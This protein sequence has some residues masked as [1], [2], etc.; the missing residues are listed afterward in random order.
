MDK[1]EADLEVKIK[2]LKACPDYKNSCW[3]CSKKFRCDTRDTYV[4]AVYKSMNKGKDGG[5]EF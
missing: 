2:E 3:E 5:F 1:Y 4:K